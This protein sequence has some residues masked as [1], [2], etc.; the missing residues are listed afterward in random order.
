[1][2]DYRGVSSL[3]AAVV[4][5]VILSSLMIRNHDLEVNALF[6]KFEG[7]DVLRWNIAMHMLGGSL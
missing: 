6:K 1:M 5:F 3:F 2:V 7:W 4:S